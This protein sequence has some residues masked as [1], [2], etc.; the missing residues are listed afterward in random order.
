[1]TE[2]SRA[3]ALLVTRDSATVTASDG[4]TTVAYDKLGDRKN[5]SSRNGLYTDLVKEEG[6][7]TLPKMGDIRNSSCTLSSGEVIRGGGKAIALALRM[8]GEGKSAD[9]II[10]AWKTIS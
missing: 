5:Q 3:E 9:E 1:M 10:E 2:E 4:E 7:T 8:R 6:Y